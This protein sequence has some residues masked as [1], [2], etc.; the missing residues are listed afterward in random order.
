MERR[1]RIAAVTGCVGLAAAALSGI[2]LATHGGGLFGTVN[3]RGTIEPF[4]IHDRHLKLKIK[5]VE[6]IDVA[7]VT[8]QLSAHGQTGWHTH[9]TDS[10]VSV[11]AGGP[12]L[13]MV[14]VHGGTC[15]QRTFAAGTSF[16][17]P[18][19]PHNFMNN[20]EMTAVTF[21]V[22]YF[23]PV[24]ATLLTPVAAPTCP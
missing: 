8:T 13:T 6:P 11:K 20:D 23:V 21:G 1:H 15:V 10:I 5:A 17:H 24:A 14:E 4:T 19:G 16:V 3:A 9:P 12:A 2:A 22:A 7:I 18:A